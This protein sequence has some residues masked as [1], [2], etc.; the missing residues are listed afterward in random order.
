MADASL[1]HDYTLAA[2]TGGVTAAKGFTSAALHSGIKAK[3]GALD[4]LVLAADRAA[5]VAALFTTNLAQAAPV[6]VSKAHLE[7]SGGTAR[8]IV[9]NSGCANAC[10]GDSGL[11]NAETMT[12]EV[13]AA[14]GCP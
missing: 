11:A 3:T 5:A 10:T 14:L 9:V 12:A 13:A 4:L 2:T 8:A 7:R 6:L 1:V